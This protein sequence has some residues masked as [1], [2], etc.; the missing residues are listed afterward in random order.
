MSEK[1]TLVNAILCVAVVIVIYI[2]S[3]FI[4]PIFGKFAVIINGIGL[5][6]AWMFSPQHRIIYGI[7]RLPVLIWVIIVF[8]QIIILQFNLSLSLKL[9]FMLCILILQIGV[10]ILSHKIFKWWV[11]ERWMGP[12]IVNKTSLLRLQVDPPSVTQS[13]KS[14]FCHRYSGYCTAQKCSGMNARHWLT[15]RVRI[16]PNHAPVLL[17]EMTALSFMK[18][19]PFRE[20]G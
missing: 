12:W 8:V 6:L 18:I 2:I 15:S 19:L 20:P 5:F 16:F 10:A 4:N 14:C 9:I 11:C 3:I 1:V 7:K 13:C 17:L